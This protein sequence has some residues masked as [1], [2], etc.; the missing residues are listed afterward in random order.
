MPAVP[1]PVMMFRVWLAAGV[2]PA[3]M[4]T[5]LGPAIEPPLLIRTDWPVALVAWPMV[6]LPVP[7]VPPIVTVPLVKALPIATEPVISVSPIVMT[8]A[9]VPP[10][11]IVLAPVPPVP[12]EIVSAPVDPPMVTPPVKRCSRW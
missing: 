11:V 4:P 2:A 9:A 3:R 7:A 6:M 10:T 8:L 5:T 1:T 12:M